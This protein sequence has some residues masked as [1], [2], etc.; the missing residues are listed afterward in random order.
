MNIVMREATFAVRHIWKKK[1]KYSRLR[2]LQHPVHFR[3]RCPPLCFAFF[4]LFLLLRVLSMPHTTQWSKWPNFVSLHYW[5]AP[6]AGTGCQG[7]QKIRT[8][9]LKSTLVSWSTKIQP[10]LKKLWKT[11]KIEQNF[12]EGFSN[13]VQFG[14][15]L[16]APSYQSGS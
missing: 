8:T 1:C 4:R 5:H 11:I 7:C 12:S 13:V 2:L 9:K 15:N 10:K 14:L 6:R 3:L 16:S